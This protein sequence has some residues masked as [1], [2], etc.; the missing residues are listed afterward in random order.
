MYRSFYS[1]SR[2]PFSKEIEP[3]NMFGSASYEELLA[4]LAFL[5]DNR[6]MGLV[7]GEAG[8]GKT[9]ALRAFALSLNS[10]LF[11]VAYFP[12]STVT[13]NDF[14]RGLAFS[15][16]ISPAF[17]KVDLFR[18]IQDAITESFYGKKIT[19]LIILDE[20]QLA[21]PTFLNELHLLFNFAMD[22]HNPFILVLCGMPS[23][24]N[25]LSL[26][27]Q[28]P[29]NQRLIMRYKMQPLSKPEV[30]AYIDHQMKLAGAN[31]PV[32]TDN[33]I[34]AITTVSRGW[35]RLINSLASTSL[36]YGCQKGLQ[37]VD[38]DAVRMAA[39]EVGL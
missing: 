8:S 21:T 18:Q 36:V 34:E 37:Q 25:K 2:R 12:L 7:T 10:S 1:L 9:S 15:L 17:R 23:L 27:H 5:K 20:L 24:L 11:K 31:Y 13:V 28:Q 29:L 39:S 3:G 33:A 14:Y 22:A 19:P 26:A 6:G 32:F 38:E 30:A 16:D 35:P 4:R